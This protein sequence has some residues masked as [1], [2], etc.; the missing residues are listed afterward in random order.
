VNFM[1]TR[2]VS[3]RCQKSNS[4]SLLVQTVLTEL[5]LVSLVIYLIEFVAIVYYY[6]SDY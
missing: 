2:K 1:K 3:Y 4:D 6:T 5:S